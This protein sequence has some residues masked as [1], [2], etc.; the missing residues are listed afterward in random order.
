MDTTYL[1]THL[2]DLFRI[3][4]EV[5]EEHVT[6]FRS[7]EVSSLTFYRG[8]A[9]S[10]WALSPRLYRENLH[11]YEQLLVNDALRMAP[12]EFKGLSDF[13][14]LAKMQHLGLPTRLLDVTTN[15][16]AALLFACIE[17][18]DEDGEVTIFPNL[19]TTRESG[20]PCNAVMQFV[21]HHSWHQL[22][23]DDF[24]AEVP[25]ALPLKERTLTEQ[26]AS[27][28]HTLTIPF[29]AVLPDNSNPRLT[30]QAGA[31]L[32]CGMNVVK[33]EISTNAGTRGK[34]YLQLGPATLS[35]SLGVSSAGKNRMKN[36]KILV[37]ASAKPE[38]LAQLDQV[39][40][41][42]WRLFP[43]PEHQMRYIYENYKTGRWRDFSGWGKSE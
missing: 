36:L 38:L 24:A 23:V 2:E 21:F 1:V 43:E 5:R 40:V 4:R 8:Q 42:R 3:I 39:N 28:R 10:G 37:P 12:D 7:S 13:Q 16:M 20:Y 35:D 34:M 17:Q 22:S 31:F 18:P 26:R 33:E 41:N 14:R 9:S 32:L 6:E 15:P 11:T 25:D 29:S 19:P 27:V 30:A